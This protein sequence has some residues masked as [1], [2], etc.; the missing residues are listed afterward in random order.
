MLSVMAQPAQYS[1]FKDKTA[2]QHYVERAAR[3]DHRAYEQLY[4]LHNAHIYAL[5]LRMTA[6]T[7][8][9][10]DATQD[11]FIQGWRKLASFRGDSAF[12][13]WLHRIAVNI[14]L[15]AMR[16][17][18]REAAGLA[19]AAAVEHETTSEPEHAL[20]D[21]E[22]AIATLPERA[23][24]VF[25]LVGVCGYRH[26]EAAD[27]LGVAV[28]TCKAHMHRARQLLCDQLDGD[29]NE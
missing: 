5:C 7:A 21:V 1:Q 2:D 18:K 14:V 9:A 8:A 15:S 11:T 13:S 22:R 20:G 27:F 28:G 26:D 6:N 19:L 10:E 25:V 23:R 16:K 24:Q 12:S 3:G 29:D 4:R 17:N